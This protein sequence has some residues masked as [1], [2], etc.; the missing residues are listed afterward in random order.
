MA[1]GVENCGTRCG[2]SVAQGVERVLQIIWTGGSTRCGGGVAQGVHTP[3]LQHVLHFSYTPCHSLSTPCATP[4]PH[5]VAQHLYTL[6][7]TLVL[8]PLHTLC[9]T[10]SIPCATPSPHLVPVLRSLHT[11]CLA[12]STQIRL[13]SAGLQVP[14]IR[15]ATFDGRASSRTQHVQHQAQRG[16]GSSTQ[17]PCPQEQPASLNLDR[18]HGVSPKEG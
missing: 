15:I 11:L 7:H 1:Q 6:C 3:S 16:S 2:E 8:L 14:Q 10:L 9:Y 5:P 18:A 17:S 4:S 13:G 12:L